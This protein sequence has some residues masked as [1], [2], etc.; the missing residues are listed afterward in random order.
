[1]W[2][3]ANATMLSLVWGLGYLIRNVIVDKNSFA[4]M[5]EY[6]QFYTTVAMSLTL[7]TLTFFIPNWSMT[8]RRLHDIGLSGWYAIIGLIPLVGNI[9]LMCILARDS[10]PFDNRWGKTKKYI[11]KIEYEQYYVQQNENSKLIGPLVLKELRALYGE[12]EVKLDDR[13]STNGVEGWRSLDYCVKQGQLHELHEA[14]VGDVSLRGR[15]PLSA[16]I[17]YILSI[18]CLLGALKCFNTVGGEYFVALFLLGTVALFG[19]AFYLTKKNKK[20]P[21][22]F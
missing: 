20:S 8:V 2:Y 22:K 15:Q 10:E 21:S 9:I 13:I 11:S 17:C 5:L 6:D 12:G 1:M 4:T 18:F 14:M 16:I 19:I 7:V 3:L